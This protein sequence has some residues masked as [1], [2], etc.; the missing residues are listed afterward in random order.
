MKED[1]LKTGELILP[2]KIV[3]EQTLEMNPQESILYKRLLV[4]SK[5]I[6]IAYANESFKRSGSSTVIQSADPQIDELLKRIKRLNAGSISAQQIMV[7]LIRLRQICCHP[8]LISSMLNTEEFS[9]MGGDNENENESV[10]N[11]LLYHDDLMNLM[12]NVLNDTDN[13]VMSHTNEIFSSRYE[14]TKIKHLLNMLLPIMRETTDK[15]VIVSEWTSF[16]E[17]IALHLDKYNFSHA[18]YTGKVTPNDRAAIKSKFNSTSTS[19]RVS[20]ACCIIHFSY[21]LI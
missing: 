9:E 12:D 4:F 19:P 15:V 7:L 6:F 21:S 14:S 1:L 16:L 13:S 10:S 11:S 18:F 3:I 2:R 8:A 5:S 20:K 17:I